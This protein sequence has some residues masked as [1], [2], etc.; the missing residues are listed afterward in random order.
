MEARAEIKVAEGKVRDTSGQDLPINSTSGISR[1][2][3]ILLMSG[4]GVAVLVLVAGWIISSWAHS[5]LAVPRARV[6]IATVSRGAFVRDVAAE[7]TVVV[8]NSPTLF[9]VAA[10]TV[11][12]K[13]MAGS[14]VAPGQVLAIIDSPALKSELAREQASLDGL[15]VELQRQVIESKQVVDLASTQVRASE[16][17][18][19]RMKSGFDQGVVPRRDLDK[20]QD[21]RDDARVA[22]DHALSSREFELR[23]KRTDVQR[24]QLLV[25]ELARRVDALTVRSPVKGMVGDFLVNQKAAVTENAALLTVVDLSALEVEFSVPESYGADLATQMAAD[26]QYGGK[27][28][29]GVV[30]SISPQV[31]QHE[32]K[33][34]L[35]FADRAPSGLRQNQRVNV[36][37]VLDERKDVLKVE[38]GGFVDSGSI[39]YR[40]NGDNAVR[41]P[42]TL[43]AMSVGEVEVLSGLQPGDQIIVSSVSDFGG[44]REVRLT[45]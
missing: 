19:E 42:V 30:T 3:R 9:A 44:A 13:V 4:C 41:Q 35:S 22:Y 15:R 6:R 16:R 34:R 31:Q 17:E 37:I 23:S 29:R 32:V 26:I 1:R 45:D 24:Q 10:G 8:A 18:L 39:V 21:A 20:A 2:R 33:G 43:G 11:T 5:N 7:G 28:Y 38:R 27:N 40:I 12:F 25:A 14:G 36:R